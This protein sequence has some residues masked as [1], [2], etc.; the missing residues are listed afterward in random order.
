MKK[1]INTCI[2]FYSGWWILSVL[3]YPYADA[4]SFSLEVETVS[5]HEVLITHP[6]SSSVYYQMLTTEDVANENWGG[7]PI[8]C[9]ERKLRCYGWHCPDAEKGKLEAP[10]STRKLEWSAHIISLANNLTHKLQRI[11]L[12]KAHCTIWRWFSTI[13]AP[14]PQFPHHVR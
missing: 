9:L 10:N 2:I 8:C 6:G 1:C 12:I 13:H 7:A 5:R 4:Q 3:L 11:L 14:L